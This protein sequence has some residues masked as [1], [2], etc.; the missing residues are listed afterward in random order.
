MD[1]IIRLEHV[2][3]IYSAQ[4]ERPIEA[5]RDISLRIYPGEYVVIL[6]RNG[7]G[8][9]TLA[10]H[11]NGILL[12][13][14]GDVWVKEWNTKD[15]QHKLAIRSTVGLVFQN[16]D[17]QIVATIVEEDVAFGPENL[18]IPHAELRRRVDWAL[19]LVGMTPYRYRPPH[20]LSGGQK[21]RIAIAGIMAMKPEVLVLDESTA[22]LDPRGRREILDIVQR[23][24]RQEGVTVVAITHF[25]DEAIW[26]D[27]IVV[28]D[29]GRL[30]MSGSPE[31]IFS[32][33]DRLRDHGLDVPPVT[34]L[35]RRL[36]RH[37]PEIPPAVLRVEEL[38]TAVRDLYA[39]RFVPTA[40]HSETAQQE[41]RP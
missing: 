37:F 15:L 25:M 29:E 39:R 9:S 12:P 21:Q 27:R 28:L 38:V 18:G 8:K 35:A 10:K 40:M 31:E 26:A 24:H 3:H 16:P 36:H 17:N 7:S 41:H 14:R 23:L 33:P 30:V 34:E 13:T 2:W 20:H 1:P 6:G 5:L 22:L 19:E 32:Q 11:L 4:G